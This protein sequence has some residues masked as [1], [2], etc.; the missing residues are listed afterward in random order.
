MQSVMYLIITIFPITQFHFTQFPETIKALEVC[1]KERNGINEAIRDLL[2][3]LGDLQKKEL[4]LGQEM[5][6]KEENLKRSQ[7]TLK[8]LRDQKELSTKALE[9]LMTTL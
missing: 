7:A 2:K 6:E 1:Q 5:A 3:T 4:D 9:A 8:D